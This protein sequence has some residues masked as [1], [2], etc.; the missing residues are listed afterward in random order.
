MFV[1]GVELKDFDD[2]AATPMHTRAGWSESP[3]QALEAREQAAW[4]AVAQAAR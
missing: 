1:K 2:P 4:E 3:W